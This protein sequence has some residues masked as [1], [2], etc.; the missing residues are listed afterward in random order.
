MNL[1]QEKLKQTNP[2]E[3]QDTIQ[4]LREQ[5]MNT[6]DG[7]GYEIEPGILDSVIYLNALGYYTNGSCEGHK[8]DRERSFAW[9]SFGNDIEERESN[10]RKENKSIY[11]KVK[12]NAK[13]K[14]WEAVYEKFPEFPEKDPPEVYDYW[15]SVYQETRDNHPDYS[16]YQKIN[17]E[18]IAAYPAV[19]EEIKNLIE[20]YQKIY[21]DLVISLGEERV[22]RI[23]FASEEMTDEDREDWSVEERQEIKQQSDKVV[24][25]F[26]LFLKQK[27]ENLT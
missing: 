13:R 5:F 1:N 20:E 2:Q 17:S 10:L 12:D 21:P 9:I 16:I 23:N 11:W 25:N 6:V 15:G 14:A 7:A 8:E 27:Y 26:E 22:P 24:K 3:K 4:K 18:I 19:K